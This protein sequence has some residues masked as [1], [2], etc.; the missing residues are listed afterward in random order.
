MKDDIQAAE[1][2]DRAAAKHLL[3]VAAERLSHGIPLDEDLSRW[4]GSC[5]TQIV[6]GV[7]PGRA[8][9]IVDSGRPPADQMIRWQCFA[10]VE[11]L[12]ATRQ[13]QTVTEAAA[14]VA[15]K[16]DLEVGSVETYRKQVIRELKG[17]GFDIEAVKATDNPDSTIN[18]VFEAVESIPE[19]DRVK[20]AQTHHRK[21]Q[22]EKGN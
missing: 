5:L 15:E 18:Q 10:Q 9:G 14:V 21:R 2:G 13:A 11:H 22:Q 4:L 3:A 12:R 8:L 17:E 7:K 20:I 19:D 16:Y 1:R 6:A